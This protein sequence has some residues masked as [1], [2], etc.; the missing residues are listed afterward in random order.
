MWTVLAIFF[1][2]FTD[3]VGAERV[4]LSETAIEKREARGIAIDLLDYEVSP[5]YLDS[6]R[7]MG[8][9]VLHTSRWINGATVEANDEAIRAI[10]K[11]GF[12]DTIYLTRMEPTEQA[13][14]IPSISL[15]KRII[16]EDTLPDAPPPVASIEQLDQLNLLPLHQA[17]YRGKGIRIGVADGGF[18]N[19]NIMTALPKEQWL[20]YADFTDDEDD[21][22]GSTGNHGTLCLTAIIAEAPDYQGTATEAEYFLFRTEEH[23]SESPKEIDNWVAAIEMADSLGLDI[24]STSLGYTTFDN[25]HFDFTYA[26]MNGRCSRGAQAATIAARKGMLLVVA[27][28]NEGNKEWHYLSTP[29]DADSILTVGA[30]DIDG[31]IAAFSSFGPSA[32]GRVKPEVCAVGKQTV[33]LNPSDGLVMTGNGTSFACPLIAGAAACLWSALPTASNMEIRERII[34]SADR[35]TTPHAQYGYGIPD[36][37]EA[38][39]KGTE[40]NLPRVDDYHAYEVEKIWYNGQL[41]IKKNNTLYS[42]LGTNITI[43]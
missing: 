22:F 19:A 15:R 35:Y 38:Y 4:C 29:A 10:E 6:V 20:G 16:A 43:H 31:E 30:V 21:F 28:G 14:D 17:G 5:M 9:K 8:A 36:L 23:Y 39:G 25:E 1:M 7:A 2:Q 33:L 12:V 11:C 13:F 42:I 32:D 34:R 40:N 41:F 27:A 18:Y 24:V 3:K 26:D 37:W